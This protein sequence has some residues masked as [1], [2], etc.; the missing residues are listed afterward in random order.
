MLNYCKYLRIADIKI[1]ILSEVE[2]Y[3]EKDCRIFEVDSIE[4]S[5]DVTFYIYKYNNEKFEEY[6]LLNNSS[7]L[8]ATFKVSRISSIM[9]ESSILLF[10]DK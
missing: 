8:L 9:K 4:N 3:L 7:C 5:S 2:F 6:S 1:K 10:E